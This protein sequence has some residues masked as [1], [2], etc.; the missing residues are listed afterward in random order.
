MYVRI[1]DTINNFI[2]YM[3]LKGKGY[4]K[5]NVYYCFFLGY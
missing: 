1:K 5:F 4:Y 3:Y 2:F